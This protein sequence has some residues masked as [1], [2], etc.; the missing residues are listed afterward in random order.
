[1]QTHAKRQM[2]S[3]KKEIEYSNKWANTNAHN[4][5]VNIFSI[6]FFDNYAA[7]ANNAGIYTFSI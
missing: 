4:K 7:A 6:F 5:C 2:F 3:S 1:M